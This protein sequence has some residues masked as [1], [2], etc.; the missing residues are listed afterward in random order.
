MSE[1][2]ETIIGDVVF[3]NKQSINREYPFSEI[4]YLDTGSITCNKIETFQK[5]NIDEAPSRAKRLVSEDDI[6][7]STVRPNQLHYGYINNAPVNLVVSTGFVVITCK[8]E[9]IN[10]KFL[11]YYLTLNSTTEYLHSIAEASTSAYPS[12]KPSDIEAQVISLP[13]LPIQESIATLLN[14]IDNKIDLLQS[15]NLSLEKIASV[16][17]RQKFIE[18]ATDGW[19]IEKLGELADVQ[20]GYAFSS[21]DYVEFQTGHLEVL[22]MGHIEKGGGLRTNPK[23]D[24]VP[25]IEKLK[26][27]ILNKGDIIMAMTDMKDNVVI[28]G[29]PAMIDKDDK[30]VLNQRVARISLKANDKLINNYLLYIQLKDSEFVATLQSKANSGV[31]VNLS[32]D[33][34]KDSDIIIPPIALQNEIGKTITDLYIKKEFNDS[35]I[36]ILNSLRNTLLPKFMSGEVTIEL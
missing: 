5:F 4:L 29:V 11:Y 23:K 22:K 24:F 32:T 16:V 28:L 36:A 8:K 3:T 26:R 25:R 21:R 1:W 10:P 6:I 2:K 20:N 30:Y 33:A 12:L 9:F 7:Y 17:F 13:P 15:Q 34:I 18:E 35:Q 19:R 27:W 14:S 31:Q